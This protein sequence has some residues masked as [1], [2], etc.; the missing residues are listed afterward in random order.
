M[1]YFRTILILLCLFAGQKT[2]SQDLHMSQFFETPLLRNPA[3][4]GLFEGDIRVQGVYRD[5]WNSVTEG[6]RTGSFNG[7]YKMPVG[8]GND[9]MTLGMQLFYDRAGTVSFTQTKVLPA[10]NFHKSLSTEKN[11]YLS[12]GFMGGWV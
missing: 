12:A 2:W 8:K 3:L 4:A 5:Q 7:E 10:L 11:V 9:Y 6:Y 1:K